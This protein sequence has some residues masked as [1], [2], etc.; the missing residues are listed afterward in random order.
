M[1]LPLVY[2]TKLLPAGMCKDTSTSPCAPHTTLPLHLHAHTLTAT[3]IHRQTCKS[4]TERCICIDTPHIGAQWPTFKN[5]HSHGCIQKLLHA[6]ICIIL[7]CRNGH[8]WPGHVLSYTHLHFQS[9]DIHIHTT[10]EHTNKHTH[11]HTC[12]HCTLFNDAREMRV[13]IFIFF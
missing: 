12:K 5:P 9:T 8:S 4:N 7:T 2:Y 3:H 13:I 10:S 6:H 1:A 11:T